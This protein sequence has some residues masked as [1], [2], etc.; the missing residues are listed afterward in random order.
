MKK[1]IRGWGKLIKWIKYETEQ[2]DSD[3]NE[4]T[5]TFFV[6]VIHIRWTETT[7]WQSPKK[8]QL[9]TVPLILC[10]LLCDVVV[11][12]SSSL[13]LLTSLYAVSWVSCIC[14]IFMRFGSTLPAGR[15]ILYSC[16]MKSIEPIKSN[17]MFDG[18]LRPNNV[19]QRNFNT[20]SFHFRDA[21]DCVFQWILSN[22][23]GMQTITTVAVIF[24]VTRCV[25]VCWESVNFQ[26]WSALAPNFGKIPV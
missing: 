5:A 4:C 19:S 20:C 11:F 23:F 3:G 8:N 24:V 17:Y 12:I 15:I 10:N 13:F 14:A 21:T 18:K 16:I 26:Q 25:C 2:K 9:H 1:T 22:L 6:P 7:A